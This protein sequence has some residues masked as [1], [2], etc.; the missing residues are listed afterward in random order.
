LLVHYHPQPVDDCPCFEDAIAFVSVILGVY[1]ARWH[2][3]YAGL[4]GKFFDA[5]MPGGQ[6]DI[7]TWDERMRWWSLAGAKVG[8]GILI[9]FIWRLLAK[10]FLH[11]VL[12]PAFRELA[13]HFE[14]PHRR[15]YTPATDYGRLPVENGLHPIPSV[16]DL[17]STLEVSGVNGSEQSR[18]T[19][20]R[21]GLN[22]N[23]GNVRTHGGTGTGASLE[24]GGSLGMD[25]IGVVAT[26]EVKH[27]D[28]DVLTK[29]VVYAGIG[30]ISAE[31]MPLF[32]SLIGWGIK[33]W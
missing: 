1:L 11:T 31:G 27:Y 23:G 32:F 6:G 12:P 13:L 4:D 8:L 9:I 24:G 33:A 14:L 25:K 15:F 17:A 26:K 18:Q 29:V 30:M 10:S 7:W 21:R 16:I 19:I 2:S 3:V 22:L 20:K 28:A 5:V